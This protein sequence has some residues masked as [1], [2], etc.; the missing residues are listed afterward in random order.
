MRHP[1]RDPTQGVASTDLM[2]A[3]PGLLADVD[4]VPDSSKIRRFHK[5]SNERGAR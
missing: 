1:G 5:R 4:I 2:A 3:S